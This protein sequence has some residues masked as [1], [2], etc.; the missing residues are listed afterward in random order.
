MAKGQGGEYKRYNKKILVSEII[1][2]SCKRSTDNYIVHV[3]TS[4]CE[5]SL[6]CLLVNFFTSR[7]VLDNLVSM[8]L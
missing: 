8:L 4:C 2:H 3:T 1:M 7:L 5:K 6:R